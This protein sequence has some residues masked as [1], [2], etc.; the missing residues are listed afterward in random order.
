MLEHPFKK[1]S[2]INLNPPT[3]ILFQEMKNMQDKVNNTNNK[4]Y[5]TDNIKWIIKVKWVDTMAMM[6]P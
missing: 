1:S 6:A 4:F 2:S 5:T 3:W